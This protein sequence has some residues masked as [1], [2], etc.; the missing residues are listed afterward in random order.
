MVSNY[1]KTLKMR[2]FG[3]VIKFETS[4]SQEKAIIL[5]LW[6]KVL[7]GIAVK[8][9]FFA[10]VSILSAKALF[11]QIFADVSRTFLKN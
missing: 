4:I 5:K 2:H 9:E 6:K 11:F 8:Y 7:N 3:H 1:R 10:D